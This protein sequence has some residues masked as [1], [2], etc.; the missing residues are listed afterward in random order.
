M[1]SQFGENCLRN[2]C[3]AFIQNSISSNKSVAWLADSLPTM[4]EVTVRGCAGR[5]R[6]SMGTYVQ[7][8]GK[9]PG[10]GH[11][12]STNLKRGLAARWL[13]RAPPCRRTLYIYKH[14]CLL[15]DSNPIPTAQQRL[16]CG[17]TVGA[18]SCWDNERAD[19]KA[20][21]GAELFQ[22][23]VRLTLRRAKCIK[24]T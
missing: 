2:S 20:K 19:Q 5:G 17:L 3:L 6:G 10:G 7:V 14:P 12:P 23:K 4:R 13:F 15:R 18:K 24:S 11:G 8:E 9:H 21:Q 16:D 22:T 1:A